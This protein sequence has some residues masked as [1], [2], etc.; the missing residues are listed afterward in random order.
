MSA[1]LIT[2]RDYEARR[3]SPP[4]MPTKVTEIRTK[5][6]TE[7]LLYEELAKARIRDLEEGVHAGRWRTDARAARTAN[8]RSRV[9]HWARSRSGRHRP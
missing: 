1:M 6:T 9:A 4:T 2:T 7:M 5:E 8:W 3:V